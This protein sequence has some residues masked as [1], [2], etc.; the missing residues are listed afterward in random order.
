MLKHQNSKQINQLE[1]FWQ[2]Y[3]LRSNG[4]EYKK[5]LEI[6]ERWINDLY[7]SSQ[8]TLEQI[9]NNLLDI[10]KNTRLAN[11]TEKGK[12]GLCLRCYISEYIVSACKK[13]ARLFSSQGVSYQ[14]LLAFVLDDD[15]QSLI[16]VDTEGKKQLEI[17]ENETVIDKENGIFTVEILSSY[18]HSLEKKSSLR[19]WTYSQTNQNKKIVE[20]LSE[21]GFIN[22]TDW[23]LLNRI[24]KYQLQQLTEQEQSIIT[25]YREV[26]KRDRRKG[27]H[28]LRS[29]CQPPS[30][31]QLQ[32]MIDKLNIKTIKEPDILLNQLK[33]IAQQYRQ[34][35]VSLDRTFL[36][37]ESDINSLEVPYYDVPI[38][39]KEELD[40]SQTINNNLV[41]ILQG[42]IKKSVDKRIKELQ[43]S[44]SYSPYAAQ[45][46]TFL[47]AFYQE[48]KSQN[49][50]AKEIGI[51]QEKLNRI[52]S[53]KQLFQQVRKQTVDDLL[54]L[55]LKL[56]KEKNIVSEPI[57][58]DYLI[59]LTEHIEKFVDQKIFIE[60]KAEMMNSKNRTMNSFYAKT[61]I[62]Y[63]NQNS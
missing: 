14:S 24:K 57:N 5:N 29:K 63:L 39:E 10:F 54:N 43:K 25:V 17:I 56:I 8:L 62:D 38:E 55:I 4:R 1:F 50:M 22:S 53:F 40:I 21:F 41:K 7:S 32:E 61:F 20:F 36:D 16:I 11:L 60:A 44:K 2:L 13:R 12:A 45:Y 51:R 42:S 19:S 33:L 26:Y 28:T 6:A 35:S 9:V 31:E 58:N 52:M 49:Q 37:Q 48:E 47:K 30:D 59:N 18:K 46:K 3:Q 23:A 15:G 34:T 27:K